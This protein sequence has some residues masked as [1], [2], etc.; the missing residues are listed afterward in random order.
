MCF[1]ASFFQAAADNI[2]ETE[3]FPSSEEDIWILGSAYDLINGRMKH[4]QDLITRYLCF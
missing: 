1:V 4:T 2:I 3:G